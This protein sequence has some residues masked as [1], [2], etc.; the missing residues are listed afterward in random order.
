[1][2]VERRPYRG[3]PVGIL[4]HVRAHEETADRLRD[5]RAAAIEVGY[6]DTSA[7]CREMFGQ[8]PTQPGGGASD[9]EDAV[10]DP[11]AGDA[12][13]RGDHSGFRMV[14]ATRPTMPSR[15]RITHSTNTQPWMIVT[16][17]PNCAR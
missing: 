7:R 14:R 8:A 15:N 4:G 11:H 10:P 17:A 5:L 3:P 9:E 12:S 2:S 1:M 6:D 16:H 13:V